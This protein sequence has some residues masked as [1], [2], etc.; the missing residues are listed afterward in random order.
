MLVMSGASVTSSS[1]KGGSEPP[2]DN[3]VHNSPAHACSAWR[4]GKPAAPANRASSSASAAASP[5]GASWRSSRATARRRL[6]SG[7]SST[8]A[9]TRSRSTYAWGWY[10]PKYAAA[11]AGNGRSGSRPSAADQRAAPSYT[12]TGSTGGA[13]PAGIN[14]WRRSVSSCRAAYSRMRRGMSASLPDWNSVGTTT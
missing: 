8:G 2:P 11:P 7:Q 5:S 10:G 9:R 3:L 4:N 6:S 12:T 13:S 1:S 14:P